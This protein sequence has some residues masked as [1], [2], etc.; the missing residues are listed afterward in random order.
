MTGILFF[1]GM[2][3]ASDPIDRPTTP[4]PVK[5]ECLKIVPITKNKPLSPIIVSTMGLAK[6]SAVAVPLSQFSDLLQ[7]E[8]W[9]VAVHS[10]YRIETSRLEMEIYWYKNKLELA[11]KPA[12]WLERPTTQRWLG[13][14]ETI[15][16]MGIVTAGIGA[17]YHYSAGAG[18]GQ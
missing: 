14:I 7:T 11:N 3:F 2:A 8:R 18:A 15:V 10:Q 12:S 13:R 17:T 1:L 9:G 5:G 4:S 16:I 6:C